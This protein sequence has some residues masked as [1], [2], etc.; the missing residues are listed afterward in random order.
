MFSLNSELVQSYARRALYWI[1]GA[2]V[3]HGWLAAGASWVEPAIGVLLTLVTFVWSLYGDRLNGLLARVQGT[4]GVI[5]TSVTVDPNK[6][7]AVS[8][9]VATPAGVVVAPH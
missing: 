9:T 3:S 1:A 2:M 6:I 8:A 7:N 5:T 4:D